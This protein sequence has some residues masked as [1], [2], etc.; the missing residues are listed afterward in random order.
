M[1]MDN[2]LITQY[3]RA[4]CTFVS[5]EEVSERE[6]LRSSLNDMAQKAN[7]SWSLATGNL[8]SL[9]VSVGQNISES[10][11]FDSRLISQRDL[12]VYRVRTLADLAEKDLSAIQDDG[13]SAAVLTQ[14]KKSIFRG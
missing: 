13:E 4:V 14:L 7:A 1:K 11:E 3:Y 8:G 10:E 2:N 12:Y 9:L 5:T 6:K